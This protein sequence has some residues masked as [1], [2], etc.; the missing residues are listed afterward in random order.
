M[1]QSNHT[2]DRI[3]VSRGL[4]LGLCVSLLALGSVEVR[5]QQRLTG[6]WRHYSGDQAVTKY[7]QLDQINPDN[8]SNLRVL[9]RRP[10]VDARFTDAFPDLLLSPNL[11]A[12]PVLIDGVLY[13]PNGVGLVEAF[14][15]GTGE[16]LWV[17]EPTQGG[18]EGLAGSSTRGVAFWS[19]ASDQRLFSTRREYLYA[20]DAA[21]G[22]AVPSFGNNGRVNLN[23]GLDNPWA[24]RYSWTSGPLVVGDVIII[25]GNGGGT[26][27][28]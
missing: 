27:T 7:S 26:Q 20:L 8:V 24:G 14:D 25:A 12:T 1:H 5:T 6:E 4:A 23:Q 22:R 9:W 19:D 13:A 3:L 11:R 17:Q 2:A 15:P 10:A 21:T 16:T 18:L 28:C